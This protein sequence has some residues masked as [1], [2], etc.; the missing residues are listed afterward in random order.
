VVTTK[1][2]REIALILGSVLL[3]AVVGM[4]TTMATAGK[5]GVIMGAATQLNE[6]VPTYAGVL[7]MLKERCSAVSGSGSCDNICG[8]KQCLPTEENCDV[9]KSENQCLCCAGT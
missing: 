3:V 4:I 2:K 6:E 9:S 8:L 5:L 7:V 1:E